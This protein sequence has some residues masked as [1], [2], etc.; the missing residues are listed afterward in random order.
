MV[1]T[2]AT[3]NFISGEEAQRLG[4]Q[5]EKDASRMKAVNSEAKPVLGVA[6]AVEPKIGA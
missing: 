4:L 1:D 2:G 3:H 6:K 5:L